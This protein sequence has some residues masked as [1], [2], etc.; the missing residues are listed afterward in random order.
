[1]KHNRIE[2]VYVLYDLICADLQGF[3]ISVNG[4]LH[5]SIMS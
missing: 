4:V 5:T 1:M 3:E 2:L